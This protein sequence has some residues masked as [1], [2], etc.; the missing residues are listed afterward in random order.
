VHREQILELGRASID[1]RYRSSEVLTPPAWDRAF[2]TIDFLTLLDLEQIHP[3][4][5]SRFLVE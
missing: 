1:R 2:G 4:A 3:T 5:R